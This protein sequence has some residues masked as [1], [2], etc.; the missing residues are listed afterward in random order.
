[1]RNEAI[2]GKGVSNIM[3][4]VLCVACV[5]SVFKGSADGYCTFT[6][7]K[8][9]ERLRNFI[10]LMLKVLKDHVDLGDGHDGNTSLVELG[11]SRAEVDGIQKIGT[12]VNGTTHIKDEETSCIACIVASVVINI[13]G[14][15]TKGDK[16]CCSR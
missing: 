8:K 5:L 16:R 1:M 6:A 4:V 12:V 13:P 14:R 2:G 11:F 3:I 10:W 7:Q 15:V 9:K